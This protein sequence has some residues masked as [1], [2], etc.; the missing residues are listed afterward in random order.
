MIAG[1]I[2][3]FTDQNVPESVPNYLEGLGHGVTR[4]RQ[5]MVQNTKDPVIA[6]ACSR[7]G[8][9][10]VTHD[11]DFRATAK[12]LNITQRQYRAELHRII[13]RCRFPQGVKRLTEYM[14][15]IETE[16]RDQKP[17]RPLFIELFDKTI[18]IWR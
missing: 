4:L 14:E 8:H 9:V 1:P 7:A 12:R 10:L 2:P 17:G 18:K 11:K 13:M 16:W 15:T 5:V 3:F 6:F